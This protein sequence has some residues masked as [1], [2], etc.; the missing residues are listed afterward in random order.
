LIYAPLEVR[1]ET[2][3]AAVRA[4]GLTAREGEVAVLLCD[5]FSAAEIAERLTISR[6]T[7]EKHIEHVYLK[8]QVRNRRGLT[9]ETVL[10]EALKNPA[11][12][13]GRAMLSIDPT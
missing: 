8:L 10:A 11:S 1:R 9:E 13:P 7:V 12:F 2:L 4:C 6:R 3:V 5:R